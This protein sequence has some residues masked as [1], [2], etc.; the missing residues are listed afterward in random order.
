MLF[1]SEIQDLLRGSKGLNLA[2][3]FL[4]G[5]ITFEPVV[6]KVEEKLASQIVWLDAFIMNMDRT[7]KNTNMLMW[8]KQLWLIDHG[9][10]LYFHHSWTNWE[11]LAKSPFTLIK[12]HVLLPHA[13]MLD[14]TN[15]AF[16]ELLHKEK[17]REIVN[18]I[19]DDW[20][21]WEGMDQTPDELREIY[22]QFLMIRLDQSETFI[23]EAQD[24]RKALI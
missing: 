9:A 4:S 3:H 13:A 14:E 15:R 7:V 20:L 24:A 21:L 16:K 2:L 18:L 22:F 17:I 11:G 23:K 6:T 10:C 1:R 8:N 12:D 5:A 19:P